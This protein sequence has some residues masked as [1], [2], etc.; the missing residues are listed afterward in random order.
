MQIFVRAVG[1]TLT[2]DVNGTTTVAQ[3]KALVEARTRVPI[4]VQRL[5]VGDRA[6]ANDNR[7]LGDYNVSAATTLT[8]NSRLQGGSSGATSWYSAMVNAYTGTPSPFPSTADGHD[9][10]ME[11]AVRLGSTMASSTTSNIAVL[12]MPETGL[13][14]TASLTLELTATL[15]DETEG[16]APGDPVTVKN[17]GVQNFD[18]TIAL[19]DMTVIRNTCPTPTAFTDCDDGDQALTLYTYIKV[20]DHVSTGG[21]PVDGR[22]VRRISTKG[23]RGMYLKDTATGAT[24]FTLGSTTYT[25][26]KAIMQQMNVN[27][28][29]FPG[30]MQGCEL[31]AGSATPALTH[32]AG[33]FSSET[34]QCAAGPFPGTT[35]TKVYASGA[36]VRKLLMLQDVPLATYAASTGWTPVTG[37]GEGRILYFEHAQTN[38]IQIQNS[39]ACFPYPS[40]STQEAL[41]A[42][43]AA[44]A[45]LLYAGA[46][47]SLVL[48]VVISV[49]VH[50]EIKL[51]NRHAFLRA[52]AKKA[53]VRGMSLGA[54]T[55]GLMNIPWRAPG[56]T[57]IP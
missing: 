25:C 38:G 9:G 30:S 32:A 23:V 40:C 50:H 33:Q 4:A 3:V 28:N 41:E 36:P 35:C 51:H 46:A 14:A 45:A 31:V 27:T 39:S 42:T 20:S 37:E 12:T 17:V 44:P 26:K 8:M 5:S 2:L 24:T 49:F 55:P 29:C 10:I 34:A 18:V 1:R 53:I 13:I 6:L 21:A 47:L 48:L 16:A 43:S 11:F 15:Q 22:T 19:S 52:K 7:T 57:N 56:L 54:T